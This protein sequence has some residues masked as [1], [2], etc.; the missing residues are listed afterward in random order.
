[1]VNVPGMVKLTEAEAEMKEAPAGSWG[2]S[3]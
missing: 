2:F 1:M 3:V